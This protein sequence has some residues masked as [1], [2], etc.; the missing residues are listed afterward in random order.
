MSTSSQRPGASSS[1]PLVTD[2]LQY[3]DTLGQ[4]VAAGQHYMLLT[5]YESMNSMNHRSTPKSS[6]ALYIPAGGLNSTIGQTYEEIQGGELF[7][8]T[9]KSAIEKWESG[10]AGERAAAAIVSAGST[11]L[12][13]TLAKLK[14]SFL[15]NAGAGFVQAGLGLAVNNHLSV[16]YKG[17]T[18]FRE[19]SF[20][21]KFFPKNSTDSDTIQRILKDFRNGATPRKSKSHSAAGMT[22]SAFFQSP[23][24][25]TIQFMAGGGKN[26]YLHEIK[27]S[28]I[29]QMQT[30]YDPTQMVSLH[31]D[32]SPVEIDLNLT[33]KELELITSDDDINQS[34]N[35]LAD[36]SARHSTAYTGRDSAARMVK[37]GTADLTWTE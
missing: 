11:F 35:A 30:N 7:A 28:V 5:S 15:Q 9:G 25:W 3:P 13:S 4:K 29:T 32:G 8:Q 22:A 23:R 6:I 34:A 19:H 1:S 14:R 33:F 37:A 10:E 24:H 16:G 27:T 21:F 36:S 2:N 17:P 18:G 12:S 20:A 31:S 26:E